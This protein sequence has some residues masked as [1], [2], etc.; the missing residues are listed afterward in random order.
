MAE[1]AGSTESTPWWAL[2]VVPLIVG[3][4]TGLLVGL[5]VDLVEGFV[6][7]QVVLG[8]PGLW[9]AV[10]ALCVFVLTRLAMVYVTRATKPGTAELY[11]EYYHHGEKRYPINQLPGRT[12][13]SAATVGLGGS[14]G[15]ESESVLLG[16]SLAILLRRF[17]GGR[18]AYLASASGRRTLLVCGAS[19]G[20]ATVFSSP[21]LGAIYGIEMPFK[22]RLD[23]KRII[24]AAIA[25]ASSFLAAS[26]IDS[27]RG[28]MQYVAHP[29]TA[30]EMFG[31]LLVAVL[32]G[33]GAR[34]FVRAMH[35]VKPYQHGAHPWLRAVLAGLALAV[36]ASS[37]FLLLG[38]AITA[39]PGYV[40]SAW[41]LPPDGGASPALWLVAIALLLRSASVLV[42]VAGGGGGGVFTSLATNG[43]LIGVG[44][45]V[46]LGLPNVT[47]LAIAGA[48][49][50]LGSGYRIPLAA[51]G[52]LVETTGAA[53]PAAL[54]I[55]AVAIATIIFGKGSASDSQSDRVEDHQVQPGQ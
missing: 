45:A 34:V 31:V 10:P 39:G 8:L 11:P 23:G 52:L 28:L 29:I 3:S 51:A 44:V 40:A 33:L 42:S 18:F 1:E 50:F 53:L 30:L 13:A 41:V 12:L 48:C 26:L 2:L 9:F 38:T 17:T 27:S 24:P 35:R 14:Q 54:G 43:L 36:L 20:I 16:S 37:A 25:A 7:Q 49:A 6:L 55:A 47:L 4:L 32:C 22:K 21:I 19:A 5:L 15:L 46:V